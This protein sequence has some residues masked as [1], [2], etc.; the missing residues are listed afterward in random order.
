MDSKVS[1]LAL[2]NRIFTLIRRSQ[3]LEG[4]KFQ[5]RIPPPAFPP[6][7]PHQ[8]NNPANRH[9]TSLKSTYRFKVEIDFTSTGIS[10]FYGNIKS[11]PLTHVHITK[12]NSRVTICHCHSCTTRA[13]S[14]LPS[15][16]NQPS[17][18]LRKTRLL[19]V[20]LRQSVYEQQPTCFPFLYCPI[21]EQLKHP[22]S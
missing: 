5:L 4:H 20:K 9:T 11:L 15:W 1:L 21:T 14:S 16:K 17:L 10:T 6:P 7:P 12:A 2:R 8:K 19:A 22:N 3:Y 18:E 13:I